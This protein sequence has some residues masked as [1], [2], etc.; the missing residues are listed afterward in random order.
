MG[1]SAIAASPRTTITWPS[2]FQNGRTKFFFC[3][4]SSAAVNLETRGNRY[5]AA[6]CRP[7]LRPRTPGLPSLQCASAAEK[8]AATV[9]KRRAKFLGAAAIVAPS[10]ATPIK[11]DTPRRRHS[12]PPDRGEGLV[13]GDD[14]DAK[15]KGRDDFRIGAPQSRRRCGCE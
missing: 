6:V 13:R 2:I 8:D 14:D 12:R 15:L 5:R 11:F 1:T 7:K 4:A 10:F 9:K 3:C